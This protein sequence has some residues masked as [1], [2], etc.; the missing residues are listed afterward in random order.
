[1]PDPRAGARTDRRRISATAR[2]SR[3]ARGSGPATPWRQAAFSPY[4]RRARSEEHTS[5]LQSPCNLVCRLLLEKK[6]KNETRALAQ[7]TRN[8]IAM[9]SVN[10]ENSS[11]RYFLRISP[12]ASSLFTYHTTLTKHIQATKTQV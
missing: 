10:A 9:T 12:T 5:E 8:S 1:M 6:K 2:G 4:E 11:K 3:K 7:S